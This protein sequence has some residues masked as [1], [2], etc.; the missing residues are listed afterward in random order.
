MI[1]FMRLFYLDDKLGQVLKS[2]IIEG[3]IIFDVGGGS[4][5]S[6]QVDLQAAGHQVT[7]VG[8]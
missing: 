7:I 3:N 1:I 6:V 4:G 2:Q 8:F 5:T